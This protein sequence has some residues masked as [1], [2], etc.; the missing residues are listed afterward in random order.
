[1]APVV[2]GAAVAV[3]GAVACEPGGLGS[4]T[5]AYTTDQTVTRELQRH[6]AEVRWLNCT[7]SS[8]DK[9]ATASAGERSVADVHC[10]GRTDDGKDITVD[11]KVTKVV[12]GACVRGNL[13]AK[14][15][16]KE[17][18]R[19]KG[20]GNCDAAPSAPPA[21]RPSQDRPGPT[22]TVTRT[23]WCPSDAHCGPVEGK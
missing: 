6:K 19:V 4:T 5:V 22:V 8:G 1:M 23:I 11:G 15:D 13:S 12:N 17:R 3:G 2:V 18:F 20:L 7:A 9:G 16:G 10:E 21:N 14:V